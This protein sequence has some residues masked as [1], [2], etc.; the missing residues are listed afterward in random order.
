MTDLALYAVVAIALA[1]DF[2][3]GFHDAANSIATVVSTRVLSPPGWPCVGGV[4]Q[5]HRLPR[6]S[7]RRWPAPS[8]RASSTPEVLT[9]GVV[10]AGADRRDR[11]EPGHLVLRPADLARRTPRRWHGRAGRGARPASARSSARPVRRSRVFIVLV[12]ARSGWRSAFTMHGRDHVGVPATRNVQRL[13][14][15]FRRLQ[16]VSAAAFSLGHGGNDA[17]KTMGVILAVLIAAQGQLPHRARRAALGGALAPRRHR[18]SAPCRAA[19]G[20]SRRW[21]ADHQAAARRRDERRDGRRR[22][23]V[24]HRAHR[25]PG[26]HHPHHHR[27]HRRGR[28]DPAAV[29]RALGRGR[30]RGVGLD[31]HDPRRGDRLGR[32]LRGAE[33]F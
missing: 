6:S 1:F 4:L 18:A 2:I 19:G 30:P 8:P 16:L 23:A 22:H 5:L 20:S 3:N 32:R 24:L 14:R 9:I 17:Q 21:V 27:R 10:F 12:A 25:H 31:P 26:V 28:L 15:G 33:G 11:L 7:A 29:G 13:N